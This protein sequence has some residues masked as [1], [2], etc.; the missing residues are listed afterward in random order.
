[1]NLH[2]YSQGIFLERSLEMEEKEGTFG[3]SLIVRLRDL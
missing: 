3:R 2:F 1:M